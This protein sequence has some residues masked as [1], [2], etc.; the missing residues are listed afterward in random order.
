MRKVTDADKAW[1]TPEGPTL[2]GGMGGF[3]FIGAMPGEKGLWFVYIC[4]FDGHAHCDECAHCPWA[5]PNG[6][7]DALCP[8]PYPGRFHKTGLN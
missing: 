5:C 2:A 6:H 8:P 7:A 1:C 4:K 3:L